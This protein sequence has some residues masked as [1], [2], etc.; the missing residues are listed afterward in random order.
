MFHLAKHLE[1]TDY[2]SL[3]FLEVDK[4]LTGARKELGLV[5]H[6][7]TTLNDTNLEEMAR[8]RLKDD[9]GDLATVI[10]NI[11]HCEK[12]K[13]ENLSK[14]MASGSSIPSGLHYLVT[15]RI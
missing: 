4:C 1:I 15:E 10:Q 7:A 6:N 2:P 11:K 14:Y 8:K 13:Q 12:M 9:K 5:Q 3:P